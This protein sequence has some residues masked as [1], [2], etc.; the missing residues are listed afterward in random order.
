VVFSLVFLAYLLISAMQC[1][2]WWSDLNQRCSVCLDRLVLPL[3]EGTADR[4]LLESAIT[5][6]VCA[7]GHGVLVESRWSRRF[8]PQDSPLRGL[9]R[10]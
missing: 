9:V 2:W 5:E 6:S 8:R 10:V 7:Q 4:V 3:T 1:R